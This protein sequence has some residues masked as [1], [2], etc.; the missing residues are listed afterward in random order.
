[1]PLCIHRAPLSTHERL[2]GF[3]IEHYAGAFPL[4]LAPEQVR[5][6]PITD[7]CNEF[8]KRVADRLFAEQIRVSV[9]TSNERM[10]A[11]IRKAQL[12]K[13]PYMPVIGEREVE[14]GTVA[15]R[16]RDGSQI[17]DLGI[18]DLVELIR[19]KVTERSPEL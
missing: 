10:N 1:M 9:D 16:K 15:L 13:I 8:A 14:A 7:A 17:K 18:D 6:V 3:L 4:W 19:K 5:V 12:F 2:I 11:K